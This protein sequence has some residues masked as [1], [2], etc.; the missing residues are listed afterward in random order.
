MKLT[1]D[2]FN[3]LATNIREKYFPEI[4]Y[5]RDND[6]CANGIYSIELF[7]NGCIN[8]DNLIKRLSKYCK[9][10]KEN[11]KLIVDKYV[12]EM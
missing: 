4:K 10:T 7:S 1:T 3:K 11:I 9:D 8:Y 5:Y 12:E 6:M 2:F